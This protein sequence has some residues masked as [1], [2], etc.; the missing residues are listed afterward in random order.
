MIFLF[1]IEKEAEIYC[2]SAKFA[3]VQQAKETE[4]QIAEI[5]NNIANSGAI[6]LPFTTILNNMVSWVEDAVIKSGWD[7]RDEDGVAWWISLFTQ[8][9]I[10]ASQTVRSFD[11]IFKS[12]FIKY[13]GD[14]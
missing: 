10:Q 8:S 14:K 12:V 2:N 7:I 6:N 4:V 11:E 1:G 3:L 13:F 5:A 9:Y